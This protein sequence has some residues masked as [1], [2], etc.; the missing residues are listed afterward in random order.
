[1]IKTGLFTFSQI[2]VK[3]RVTSLEDNPG[4]SDDE[5]QFRQLLRRPDV[6]ILFPTKSS[7]DAYKLF[8]LENRR[9][10]YVLVV[11][12]GTWREAKKMFV[13]S[14]ALQ[15]LPAIHLDLRSLD[16]KSEYVVRTQPT[17]Q[18]LSTVEIVAHTIAILE[19]DASV[20]EK[21]VAPLR[22]LCSIQVF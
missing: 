17:D 14:P 13:R 6:F 5:R 9:K 4:L 15:Q 18:C 11:L 12:D 19:N 20:V 1:L 22:A 7:H 10:S 2:F 3:S 8:S 16:R 21:L